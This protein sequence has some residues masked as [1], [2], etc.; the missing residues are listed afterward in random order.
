MEDIAGATIH[1]VVAEFSLAANTDID[2]EKW[3]HLGVLAGFSVAAWPV[4][5]QVYPDGRAYW[6]DTPDLLAEDFPPS[7]LEPPDK[8]LFSCAAARDSTVLCLGE[9]LWSEL[10]HPLSTDAGIRITPEHLRA[11]RKYEPLIRANIERRQ[12][13]QKQRRAAALE[14]KKQQGPLDFWK[15]M[16]TGVRGGSALGDQ[17]PVTKRQFLN[18]V[19]KSLE[20][21]AR[22]EAKAFGTS[23]GAALVKANTWKLWGAAYILNGGCSEDSFL[24]FRLWLIAQGRDVFTKAVADPESLAAADLR[25]GKPG[26]FELEELLDEVDEAIGELDL[27]VSELCDGMDDVPKGTTPKFTPEELQRRYPKLCAKFA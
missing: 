13:R 23:M 10:K 17:A 18:V 15:V 26:D 4:L 27:A 24:Y 2:P 19:R 16:D 5:P 6:R 3:R 14:A 1:D 21:A 12:K 20:F 9:V 22:A 11:Y 8:K 25:F 7:V